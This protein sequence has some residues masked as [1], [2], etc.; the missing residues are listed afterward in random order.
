MNKRRARELAQSGKV[1]YGHLRALIKS[2]TRG[3][4][5]PSRC[6]PSVPLG[7]AREWYEAILEGRL[8]TEGPAVRLGKISSRD[9]LGMTN[10][11]RDFA[12]AGWHP[13]SHP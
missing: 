13:P 8:D 7:T 12:E 4:D 5:E 11:L 1:T 9:V 2:S 3:D 6:N 10:I